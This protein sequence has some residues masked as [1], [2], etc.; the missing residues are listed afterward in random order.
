MTG[1][2]PDNEQIQ[3]LLGCASRVPD[4]GKLAPWRFIT[5][6]GDAR[7]RFG[8][9]LA[10]AIRK[11]DSSV[12]DERIAQERN[13]FLRAPVVIGVISRVRTGIP[14]PEWEQVLSAGASCPDAMVESVISKIS[15]LYPS[16]SALAEAVGS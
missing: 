6:T 15:S 4:H 7:T 5:F 13:R 12:T 8:N 16:A 3:T 9:V 2:G 1:P 10:D 14:I 11:A